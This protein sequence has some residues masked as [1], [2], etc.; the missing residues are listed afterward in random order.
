[1]AKGNRTGKRILL[2]EDD[3]GLSELMLL[4]LN[5]NGYACQL[6]ERGDLVQ[7]TASEYRPDLILLDLGLPGIDGWQA[8]RELKGHRETADL[9]VVIVS[10]LRESD[11]GN[12]E[13]GAE[14]FLEKP[15]TMKALLALVEKY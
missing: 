7:K 2:C 1:M 12:K 3:E 5:E 14:A 8:L 15:F 10:A 9:P 11:A 6:V 4:M 13:A